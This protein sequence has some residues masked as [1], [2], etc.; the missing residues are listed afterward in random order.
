[1]NKKK[2]NNIQ[3]E[4]ITKLRIR[5]VAIAL[6]VLII[7]QSIIVSVS[8][9][10]SYKRMVRRADVLIDSVYTNITNN[11]EDN[12][13]DARY[14]YVIDSNNSSMPQVNNVNDRIV[15]PKEAVKSY[16][17][18][19]DINKN[20]GF[21][22]GYRYRIIK[23]D[24]RNIAIFIQRIGMID[25]V[26]KN[27]YTLG[28][29]SVVG[30]GVI[31]IFLIAI[32]KYMVMPIANAYKKQ[33]EF[34]T[35]ASHELKTPITVILADADIIEMDGGD[36]EWLKD[37]RTQAVKLRDMTNSLVTLARMDERGSEITKIEFPISDIANEVAH[38]YAAL[39][40]DSDKTFTYDI[41]QNLSM[42][43][44]MNEI[45]QLMTILLDNAFKY[46]PD[47]GK[48]YFYL[49]K[50][51]GHIRMSVENE[52][53]YI[54]PGL[55]DKMFERFYRA[56]STSSKVTGHGLGLAIAKNIVDNSGGKIDAKVIDEHSIE[57]NV[58]L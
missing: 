52:V 33:K 54:E 27:A 34:I 11:S 30:I 22:N 1:M 26:K 16:R 19:S 24:S 14:Y 23:E 35:S 46:S 55:A 2:N 5:F 3:N 20:S 56:D 48:I 37:I 25:E 21:Y 10:Y 17:T 47:N 15:K 44:N 53:D 40:T 31:F 41:A 18:I 6:Q 4:M 38:E 12:N 13:V 43:G 39:E 28:T 36:N 7:M 32:S 8:V 45:R 49:N 50:S 57:I 29:I 51:A 9:L 58:V 42:T